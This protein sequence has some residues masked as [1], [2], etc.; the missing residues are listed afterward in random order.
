MINNLFG[1][2]ALDRKS[3]SGPHQGDADPQHWSCVQFSF[4]DVQNGVS[5]YVDTSAGETSSEVEEAFHMCAS[6]A[7]QAR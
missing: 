6:L 1:K 5:V 3:Y 2:I 7:L 4:C